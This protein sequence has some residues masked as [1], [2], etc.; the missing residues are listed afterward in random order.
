MTTCKSNSKKKNDPFNKWDWNKWNSICKIIILNL[1]LTPYIKIN[2][3][4]IIGLNV[5][6]KTMK[7]IERKKIMDFMMP[8][9]GVTHLNIFIVFLLI[10]VFVIKPLS[11]SQ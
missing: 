2:A 10:C 9:P 11:N 1:I 5:K 3:K 4:E 6:P 8:T 7:L